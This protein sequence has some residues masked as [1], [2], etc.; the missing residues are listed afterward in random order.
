VTPAAEGMAVSP[1][2]H[3]GLVPA[4][5]NHCDRRR[6]GWIIEAN[7]GGEPRDKALGEEKVSRSSSARS[8]VWEDLI[9]V[10][11]SLERRLS[12]RTRK[13]PHYG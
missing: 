1:D 3:T 10:S 4:P 2:L 8:R 7:L 11:L 13:Q 12:S 9:A 6:Y 5:L